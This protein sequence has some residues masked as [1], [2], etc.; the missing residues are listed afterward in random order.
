[1]SASV[2]P[3]PVWPSSIMHR[4]TTRLT[5]TRMVGT[6]IATTIATDTSIF[7]VTGT[8][9]GTVTG[10]VGKTPDN[11]LTT[12]GECPDRDVGAG[13]P[14]RSIAPFWISYMTTSRR[15]KRVS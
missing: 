12:S 11:G 4:V 2:L 10:I 13:S 6:G 7:I 3:S 15:G 9:T 14:R 5:T 1:M 8:T